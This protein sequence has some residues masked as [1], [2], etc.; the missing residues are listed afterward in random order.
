MNLN[1]IE[2][3]ILKEEFL[4]YIGYD[5]FSGPHV[6]EVWKICESNG[7]NE[8]RTRDFLDKLF[9]LEVID[10]GCPYD[11]DDRP[12]EYDDWHDHYDWKGVKE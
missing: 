1:E 10:T 6:P 9:D 3:K 8:E 4:K 12:D 7:M 11:K 5:D 2:I